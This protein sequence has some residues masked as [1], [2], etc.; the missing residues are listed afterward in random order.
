MNKTEEKVGDFLANYFKVEYETPLIIKDK[1]GYV[2]IWYPDFY[3]PQLGLFVEVAPFEKES[4][5]DKAEA[6]N[7]E[8]KP[9]IWIKHYQI[10]KGWKRYLIGALRNQC[11]KKLEVIEKF[12]DD[13]Y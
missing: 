8:H 5:E 13:V 9:V 6:Y 4:D 11:E 10:E 12:L 2:R 1:R 7:N 3:L